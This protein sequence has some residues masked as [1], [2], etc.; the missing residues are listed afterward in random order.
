VSKLAP[1]AYLRCHIFSEII[2]QGPKI[3]FPR[4]MGG[5][6]QPI[7]F[8]GGGEVLGSEK[9][10]IEVQKCFQLKFCRRKK[11]LKNVENLQYLKIH[12]KCP[13]LKK[14]IPMGG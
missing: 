13:M 2:F 6:Y 14:L 7:F 5:L 1:E 12:Q 8:W 9:K 4:Q 11:I 10:V 3:D